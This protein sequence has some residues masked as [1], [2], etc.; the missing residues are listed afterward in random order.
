[1]NINAIRFLLAF[2]ENYN[3]VLSKSRNSKNS[4]AS[5]LLPFPFQHLNNIHLK[6]N[7]GFVAFYFQTQNKAFQGL[8]GF[9][10]FQK[11]KK[12]AKLSRVSKSPEAVENQNS[13]NFDTVLTPQHLIENAFLVFSTIYCIIGFFCLFVCFFHFGNVKNVF[14][15]ICF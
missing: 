8:L 10:V 5:E 4:S 14:Y 6:T 3:N 1:M 9:W 13:R 2:L 11:R 15:V 12:R 7:Q